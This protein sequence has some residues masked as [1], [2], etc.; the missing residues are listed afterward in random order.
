MRGQSSI[1][2]FCRHGFKTRNP[3]SA[4]KRLASSR[5]HEPYVLPRLVIDLDA[6]DNKLVKRYEDMTEE[7]IEQLRAGQRKK[8]Y[9]PP[10]SGQREV[11]R[12][13]Q[14]KHQEALKT[15]SITPPD[16]LSYA[17]LGDPNIA[18]N[19]RNSQLG[20]VLRKAG[21]Q[22]EDSDETKVRHMSS[23]FLTNGAERLGQAGFLEGREYA[24]KKKIE[25]CSSFQNLQRIV[26]M[27]SSTREGCQFLAENG[28]S[29]VEGIR[30]CRKLQGKQGSLVEVSRSMVLRL[31]NNLQRNMESKGIE[32]GT[33]LCNAGIYYAS[34]DTVLPAVKLYLEISSRNSY[35]TNNHTGRG[36]RNLQKSYQ[37]YVADD[38]SKSPLSAKRRSEI[39]TL[40]TGWEDGD[41]PRLGEKRK[42]SFASLL[43]QEDRASHSLDMTQTLYPRYI[44]ALGEMGLHN[45]LW[46][47]WN[48]DK[49]RLPLTIQGDE[50]KGYRARLFAL[51]FSVARDTKRALSV[52]E[53]ITPNPES[54]TLLGP[55]SGSKDE[56]RLTHH[57]WIVSA[58][59]DHYWFQPLRPTAKLWSKVKEGFRNL[60]EDPIRVL[61]VLERFIVTGYQ[62]TVVGDV[63]RRDLDWAE[64]DGREGLLVMPS[65]GDV[66][67]YF[68]PVE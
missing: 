23:A 12:K 64:V 2:L 66:P 47:E 33:D 10:A 68:K 63:E 5:N 52:L 15:N 29:V 44:G 6:A 7:D 34:K 21:I 53:S 51:A 11:L 25:T 40:I 32:I 27:L 22:P 9:K 62:K 24:I 58:M 13:S 61:E 45:A 30:L 67:L 4:S 49:A 38:K 60:P 31:L 57:R 48:E 41:A 3:F 50:H 8:S 1:C 26:S 14:F 16:L 43:C 39:L 36:V 55:L 20:R 65:R 35:P 28:K 46:A 42:L 19:P 56:L 59:N 37:A 18:P 17:L 54:D